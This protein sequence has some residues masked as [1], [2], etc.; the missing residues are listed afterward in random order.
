MGRYTG[1]AVLSTILSIALVVSAASTTVIDDAEGDQL[2]PFEY[3]DL[4]E[5]RLAS[6]GSELTVTLDPAELDSDQERTIYEFTFHSST[7]A[8][9]HPHEI[10]CVAGDTAVVVYPEAC[11][12][13]VT[14]DHE[15]PV[16]GAHNV[17]QSTYDLE[18][19]LDP[20]G[21]T[22]EIVVPYEHFGGSQ[23]GELTDLSATASACI[24]DGDTYV[25]QRADQASGND[26]YTL[27]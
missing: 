9:G 21:D 20:A 14:E 1:V 16:P 15:H 26:P 11:E 8:E 18:H 22:W 2:T 25:C 4:H 6:D 10:E 3:Q 7:S 23:G 27:R 24:A 12:L 5:V 19:T 13:T 17:D